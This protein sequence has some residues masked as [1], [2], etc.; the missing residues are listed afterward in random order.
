MDYVEQPW[1]MHGK[2]TKKSRF[3]IINISKSQQLDHLFQAIIVKPNLSKYKIL[4]SS[5]KTFKIDL[6][7]DL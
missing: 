7:C 5:T 4:D 1:M 2:L 6:P 3:F